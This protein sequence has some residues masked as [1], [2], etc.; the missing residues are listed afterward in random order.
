MNSEHSLWWQFNP[1]VSSVWRLTLAFATITSVLLVLCIVLIYQ[2]LLGE[3]TR[4]VERRLNA[5]QVRIEGLANKFD[6]ASFFKQLNVFRNEGDILIFWQNDDVQSQGLSF[7][8]NDIPKLPNTVEFPVLDT[9]R[10]QIRLLTTGIVYTKHG[11]IVIATATEHLSRLITEFKTIATW[12]CLLSLIFTCVFGYIFA[13]QHLRRVNYFNSVAE[14]VQKGDLSARVVHKQKGDEFVTLAK[15]INTMLQSIEENFALVQG[16]TDNIAHDLK[17]PLTR[18]R[19]HL[20]NE[21]IKQPSLGIAI[22]QLESV[23]HTF[24]A[25]LKLTRLE[26]GQFPLK[27]EPVNGFTLMSDIIDILEPTADQNQQQITLL[28][29]HELIFE[30]D[31]NL[32]FQACYNLLQNAIKYAGNGAIIT[33]TLSKSSIKI[34]DNGKGVNKQQL[35]QL[36]KRF[37][38]SDLARQ[39]DG[40]GLGLATVKAICDRHHFTLTLQSDENGFSSTISH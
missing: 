28:K 24:D 26:H 16:V 40:F 17:T 13:R 38:R 4:Q 30:G 14:Q 12:A 5:E 3:Q 2:L 36:T 1:R 27:L 19:L 18:L 8:P 20:E 23:L 32:L 39:K 11:K 25:M 33:I 31:K 34:S 9:Q 15:H 21:A 29:T 22:E 10:A 37:Y 7:F 35:S 6:K